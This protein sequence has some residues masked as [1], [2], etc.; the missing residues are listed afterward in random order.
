MV[1]E[2]YKEKSYFEIILVAWTVF[3]HILLEVSHEIL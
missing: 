1:F 2:I 3:L